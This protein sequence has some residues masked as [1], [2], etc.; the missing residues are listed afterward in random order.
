MARN[1]FHCV[2]SYPLRVSNQRASK[3]STTRRLAFEDV[4]P[5]VPPDANA[6]DAPASS[7]A[8]R[9]AFLGEPFD[10]RPVLRAAYRALARNYP[11]PFTYAYWTLRN[12]ELYWTPDG[13]QGVRTA[14]GLAPNN[15]D[16]PAAFHAVAS[17][18]HPIAVRAY[19]LIEVAHAVRWS[20]HGIYPSQ[21]HDA[22][23]VVSTD[24]EGA[25]D[26]LLEAV[27]T[28]SALAV[29]WRQ[30]HATQADDDARRA[31]RADAFREVARLNERR[32]EA[33]K[34][35]RDRALLHASEILR[36][37][38]DCSTYALSARVAELLA[39]EF[40]PSAPSQNTVY[41][42]LRSDH[43]TIGVSG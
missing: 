24:F 4:V 36:G 17:R 43:A 7:L 14:R 21:S 41:Q 35:W 16:L 34:A 39:G 31:A 15:E 27:A 32:A 13:P 28:Y 42:F 25:R 23:G 6:N 19:R 12:G 30:Y 18:R 5:I 33:S 1:P 37:D 9:R 40:A 20:A 2:A 10:A 22:V 26:F 38:P 3:S 11:A 8:L 29:E